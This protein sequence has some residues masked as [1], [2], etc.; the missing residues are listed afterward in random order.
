MLV[1]KE[2]KIV[3]EVYARDPISA[4][5]LAHQLSFIQQSLKCGRK[6]ITEAIQ[7]LDLAIEALYPHTNFHKKGHKLYRR[8]LDGTLTRKEEELISKLRVRI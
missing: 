6:G 8:L 1:P 5:A 4:L 7:A 3:F 2:W